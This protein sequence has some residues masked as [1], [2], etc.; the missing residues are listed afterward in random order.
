MNKLDEYTDVILDEIS[1]IRNYIDTF[2][3]NSLTTEQKMQIQFVKEKTKYNEGWNDGL[4]T[5]VDIISGQWEGESI[6]E[7]EKFLDNHL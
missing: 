7:I 1:N 5:I 2:N 6:S 4:F 3:A